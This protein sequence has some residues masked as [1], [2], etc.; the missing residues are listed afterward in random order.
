MAVLGRSQCSYSRA[1]M[2]LQIGT[3]PDSGFADQIGPLTVL[4]ALCCPWVARHERHPSVETVQN[5]SRWL[6]SM[7]MLKFR[8]TERLALANGQYRISHALQTYIRRLAYNKQIMETQCSLTS[9]LM[10]YFIGCMFGVGCAFAVLYTI[11]LGG[12]RRA[13]RDAMLDE[14]PLRYLKAIE[15]NRRYAKKGIFNVG[16]VKKGD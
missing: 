11:Y 5:A 6:R 13:L 4:I 9:L 12:Y 14:K 16:I 8:S 10:G 7:E 15:F 1:V 2:G 3:K